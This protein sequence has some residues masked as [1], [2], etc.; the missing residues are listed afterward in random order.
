VH[1]EETQSLLREVAER[2][3]SLEQRLSAIELAQQATWE[4]YEASDSA[5]RAEL[6]KY[7]K[8]GTV[9]ALASVVGSVVRALIL[10]LLF[11][12]AYRVS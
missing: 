12:V 5:Y 2:Q 10:F 7:Q 1:E 3:K 6:S 4:K 11:Y 8:R 9:H